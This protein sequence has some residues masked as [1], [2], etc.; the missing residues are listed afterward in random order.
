[1][2]YPDI[3]SYCSISTEPLPNYHYLYKRDGNWSSVYSSK[4]EGGYNFL[5]EREKLEKSR[6][7]KVAEGE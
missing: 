1:M 5:Q 4:N 7:M 2:L 3:F 6:G